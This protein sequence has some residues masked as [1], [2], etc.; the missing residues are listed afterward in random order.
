MESFKKLYEDTGIDIDGRLQMLQSVLPTLEKSIISA[1]NFLK[2]VPGF[3]ALTMNDQIALI[4]GR[5]LYIHITY[6]TT[7]PNNLSI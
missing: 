6:F 7:Y 1:I 4:K 3:K 2:A 5:S